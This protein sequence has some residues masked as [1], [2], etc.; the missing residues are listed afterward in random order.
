MNEWVK[1]KLEGKAKMVK[2]RTISSHTLLR[3]HYVRSAKESLLAS[4]FCQTVKHCW[5]STEA[6]PSQL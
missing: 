6:R 1:E 5:Q 3:G 4:V 2:S